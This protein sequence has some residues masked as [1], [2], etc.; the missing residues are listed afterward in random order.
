MD[1]PLYVEDIL[2]AAP[3]DK[4]Q[5]DVANMGRVWLVGV[6]VWI[7]FGVSLYLLFQTI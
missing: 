3:P 1:D 7:V 6:A 4:A 5:S 2:A